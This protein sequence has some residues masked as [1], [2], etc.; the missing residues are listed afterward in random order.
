MQTAD[1][2]RKGRRWA[3]RRKRKERVRRRKRRDRSYSERRQAQTEKE[4]ART[5]KQR[6]L[7]QRK[8]EAQKTYLQPNWQTSL[9]SSTSQRRAT[10]LAYQTTWRSLTDRGAEIRGGDKE[11]KGE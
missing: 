10:S 4:R 3:K 2:K 9:A 11:I 6:R 5:P 7:E 8:L 1:R